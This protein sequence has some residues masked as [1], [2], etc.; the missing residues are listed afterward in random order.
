ML[1]ESTDPHVLAP[2]A[3]DTLLTRAHWQRF[4][5]LGDSV[6][7]HPGEPHDG[8]RDVRWGDRIAEALRRRHPSL[9][10][11]NVGERDRTIAEI[12][13][14]QL[15]GVLAFNPDLVAVH[16]GG[17]D[18]FRREF[19]IARVRAIYEPMVAQLKRTGATVLTWATLSLSR[20]ANLP[21]PWGSRLLDRYGQLLD[22][23]RDVARRQ[24]TLFVDLE[25]HPAS[26]DPD[27]YASD[28]IH[29]N[30]RGHAI[31]AS[32]MIAELGRHLAEEGRIAA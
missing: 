3:A 7:G 8:Y 5:M 10:Y 21:E 26:G 20:D 11:L 2:H 25:R 1:D 16:G 4:A 28:V 17:N 29:L 15:P 27:L 13:A 24:D 23:F 14:D 12:A 18:T 9:Q 30:M 31:V 32:A 22:M 6:V 19:D